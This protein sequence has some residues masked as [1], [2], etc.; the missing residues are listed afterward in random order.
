DH[1][2]AFDSY[3]T[4]SLRIGFNSAGFALLK[5]DSRGMIFEDDASIRELVNSGRPLSPLSIQCFLG[6]DQESF[7]RAVARVFGSSSTRARAF[8]SFFTTTGVIQRPTLLFRD[9]IDSRFAYCAI[10]LD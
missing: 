2:A 9:P 3:D 8:G 5:I 10:D 4:E 7:G 6:H 1:Q